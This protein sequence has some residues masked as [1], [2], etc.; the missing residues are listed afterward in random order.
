MQR[1]IISILFVVLAACGLQAQ[2]KIA[3][4]DAAAVLKRMPEAQDAQAQLDRLTD[5]WKRDALSME[6]ELGRKRTEYERKK[7]IMTDAERNA[8]ELDI[9]ELKKR[10]DK[11]RQDKFGASG[12]LFSQ[13]QT[14]MKPV[15][16]KLLTAIQEV[17]AEAKYDYVFDRSSKDH[18][19]LY[20]N[21]KFDLTMAVAKKLGLE[22]NDVFNIPL[23]NKDVK[24]LQE[25]PRNPN[26]PGESPAPI[27]EPP[28]GTIDKR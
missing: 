18:L 16:D 22:T 21:A 11:Y 27:H 19:M 17:A 13:Q 9:S 10:L 14:L 8:I 20:S 5:D 23:L 3:F 2:S 26:T 25:T 28:A 6:Q 7:L 4:L 15:Y 12:E 1:C 24:P